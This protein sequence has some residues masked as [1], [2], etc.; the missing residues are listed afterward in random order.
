MFLLKQDTTRKGWVDKKTSQLEFEDDGEGEEYEVEAIC[1]S[2]VYAKESKSGQL[3][4][5]YFL[6]SWKGF[7]EEEILGNQL[8]PSS[9]SGSLSVPSINQILISQPQL[10]LLLI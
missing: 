1:D 3:P 4:G 10:Q 9:T 8:R 7:P 2:A 6:I 5:L